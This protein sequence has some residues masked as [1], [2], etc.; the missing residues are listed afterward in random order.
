MEL[1]FYNLN[2][3]AYVKPVSRVKNTSRVRTTKKKKY[4]LHNQVGYSLTA[5]NLAFLRSLNAI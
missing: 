1:Q 3:S 5:E 4:L 2:T